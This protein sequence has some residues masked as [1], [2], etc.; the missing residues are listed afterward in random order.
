M[1]N[2]NNHTDGASP[3]LNALIN[4]DPFLTSANPSTTPAG[5]PPG[6]QQ[7]NS[8]ARQPR[9]NA[10]GRGNAQQS[11]AVFGQVQT[12]TAP[13][14]ILAASKRGAP[15][16]DPN[17]DDV[18]QGKDIPTVFKRPRR[19]RKEDPFQ[20]PAASGTAQFTPIPPKV[21]VFNPQDL[22]PNAVPNRAGLLQGPGTI[23]NHGQGEYY[24]SPA[25]GSS[26]HGAGPSFAPSTA[27]ENIVVDEDD[28]DQNDMD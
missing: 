3:L 18:M 19:R 14:S 17:D 22:Y 20:A 16:L 10:A 26:H 24:A 11:M 27:E 7:R 28:E 4:R 9:Q 25:A 2:H 8:N 6:A 15:Q 12:F 13:A 21:F 5:R 23:D 1:S